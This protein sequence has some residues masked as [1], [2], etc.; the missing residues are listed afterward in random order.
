M[1]AARNLWMS[2]RGLVSVAS[3]MDTL[4]R[5]GWHLSEKGIEE[6]KGLSPGVD[7]DAIVKAALNGDLRSIGDKFLP[8]EITRGKVDKLQGPLVLQV[9]KVR[10]VAAPREQES[11]QGAPRMLRLQLT[12]GHITCPAIE[13]RALSA[14]GLNTPPGSKVCL[15]GSI[16]VVNGFMLLEESNVRLLGGVVE[17]LVEKWQLQQV[18]PHQAAME[19]L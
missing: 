4:K 5:L 19:A 16:Q 17:H 6:C 13:F 14:I 9:V 1:C 10:N 15:N 2:P 11:C 12:D 18:R 3:F 7:T 8:E